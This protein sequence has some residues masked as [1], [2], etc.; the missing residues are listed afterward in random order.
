MHLEARKAMTT[1]YVYHPLYLEHKLPGHPE[2][3]DRLE[4]VMETLESERILDRLVPLEPK[5]ATAAEIETVHSSAHRFRVQQVSARGGGHLDPDTYVNEHSYEAA[6]LAAGGAITAVRAVIGG[7]VDNAFCLVRPP[8]HHATPDRGMGFCLFNNIAIAARVAQ[9]EHKLERVMIVDYDVHHGNGTQD[10]FIEDPSILFFSTH[11][12]GY[13]YPGTGSWRENGRR[14]GIGTTINVPLPSGVGDT[15]YMAVFRDLLWPAAKRFRPQL[16]LVSAG[17]DAHWSDP[18]AAMQLSLTGYAN[19]VRELC[20]IAKSLCD[21]RIVFTLEGGYHLDV[22]AYST[23]N[24]FYILLGEDKAIDPI[25]P[26]PFDEKPVDE[27]VKQL[28]E[29]HELSLLSEDVD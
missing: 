22:L 2:S 4:R 23:L 19:L 26:A 11:Q 10:V 14:E 15:G 17:F 28:Q 12:Y 24:T 6:L 13:F 27:L 21:G 16:I 20:H 1:G 5:A 7:V 25:G 8:G 9:D 3:P 29:F 18:L